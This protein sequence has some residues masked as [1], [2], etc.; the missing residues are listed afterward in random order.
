MVVFVRVDSLVVNP[1]E[2]QSLPRSPH[3]MRSSGLIESYMKLYCRSILVV[4][5]VLF[6]L[7]AASSL[8]RAQ[9]AAPAQKTVTPKPAYTLKVSTR[10]LITLSLKA[11]K[12]PLANI[13]ADVAK[14]LRI[15][16][17]LGA[18]VQKLDVTADFKSLTLEPAMNLLAPSV[19][20]DY[21]VNRG[22][23]VPPQAV[24]IYLNGYEDAAPAINATVSNNA[25]AILI[26]GDTEEGVDDPKKA[27]EKEQQ[28]LRISYER[29]YLT[30]K[31]I[32]Q[33]LSVVLYKIASELGIPLEIR[34]DSA[35]MVNLDINK[36]PLE[37]AVLRLSPNVRLYIRADLQRSERRPFRMVLVAPDKS[38]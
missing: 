20:I 22:P 37:D 1:N 28:P 8:G 30:V 29:N 24:G 34:S 19:Y 33:P 16:V 32:Q 18:S 5:S 12:A 25:Q 2:I 4:V 6:I 3:A 7:A 36:M 21:E 9:K 14:K 15:P 35:E 38:S 10:D 13:A 23:G 31:A 27:A 11:D 17:V 26:E